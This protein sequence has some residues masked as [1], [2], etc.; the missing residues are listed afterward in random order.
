MDRICNI[1]VLVSGGGT[2]LQAIIDSCEKGMLK[3]KARVIAVISNKRDAYG[4]ERARKHGIDAVFVNAQ[5]FESNARFCE[6]VVKELQTRKVAL[7]C[8]AGYLRMIEPNMIKAFDGNIL[9]VHPALL[10]KYGGAGMYGH[11]V[12]EAVLRSREK[13]SGATVH[14]V[15]EKYDHGKIVIQKKVKVMISDTPE[16]LAKRVLE[17]EHKIYPEAILRIL[18]EK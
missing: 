9:N 8:L 16:S 10:P 3:G 4:L 7:V 6:E 12:H 15:D 1:G 18:E 17:V 5:N 13:E 14:H 2:N 11:K